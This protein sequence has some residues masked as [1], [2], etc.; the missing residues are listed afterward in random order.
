MSSEQYE[1]GDIYSCGV[2]RAGAVLVYV[3]S[4]VGVVTA[5]MR[6]VLDVRSGAM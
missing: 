2:A 3:R 5:S 6:C 4:S 1:R